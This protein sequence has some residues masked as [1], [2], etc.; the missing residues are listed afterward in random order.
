MILFLFIRA[1][2]ENV[3]ISINNDEKQLASKD[4][5]AGRELSTQILSVISELCSSSNTTLNNLS[6]I[7]VYQGPGSYTG[8]RISISVAN[9][10]GYALDIPVIGT[11]GDN[12]QNDGIKNINDIQNFKQV[13]PLYGGDVYTTKPKK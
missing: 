8:L 7:V 2:S 5:R 1:D 6:G 4:W 12:W 11:G 13:S 3:S 10:L 9:S